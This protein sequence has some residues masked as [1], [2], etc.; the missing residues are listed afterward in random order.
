MFLISFEGAEAMLPRRKERPMTFIFR[1]IFWLALA[2]VVVPPPSR[3]GG[4]DVADFRDVD[5]ELELH[6]A[7]WLAWSLASQTASACDTNPQL[8]KAGAKLWETGWATI[9]DIAEGKVREDDAD[10]P[11][12]AAIADARPAARSRIGNN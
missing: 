10:L 12:E 9:A 7:A 3:L 8:C 1:T 5:I 2:I 11:E 6:N 4:R